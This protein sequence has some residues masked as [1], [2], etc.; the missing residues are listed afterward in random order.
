MSVTARDTTANGQATSIIALAKQMPGSRLAPDR[1]SVGRPAAQGREEYPASGPTKRRE[2]R[3]RKMVIV[4]T[5]RISGVSRRRRNRLTLRAASEAV[6]HILE[7]LHYRAQTSEVYDSRA[8]LRLSRPFVPSKPRKRLKAT[9]KAS[10]LKQY[11]PDVVKHNAEEDVYQWLLKNPMSGA[12]RLYRRPSNNT[13]RAPLYRISKTHYLVGTKGDTE[14]PKR[15]CIGFNAQWPQLK[16]ECHRSWHHDTLPYNKSTAVGM[17]ANVV[18]VSNL[19]SQCNE[20]SNETYLTLRPMCCGV[21]ASVVCEHF[22]CIVNLA[23]LTCDH[24]RPRPRGAVG[25]WMSSTY[26]SRLEHSNGTQ[27]K[28]RT[29]LLS[30]S[31]YDDHDTYINADLGDRW[32]SSRKLCCQRTRKGG[33]FGSPLGIRTLPEVKTPY[34]YQPP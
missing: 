29:Q 33:I 24:D 32:R 19:P 8:S 31:V 6:S 18:A 5:A 14:P 25:D 26:K 2:A 15:L 1:W 22:N 3:L 7:F 11:S 28:L 16:E 27:H 34:R 21:A 13:G 17:Q 9:R 12:S 4:E 20:M 23:R 10:K 30:R